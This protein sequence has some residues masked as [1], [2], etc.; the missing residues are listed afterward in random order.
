MVEEGPQKDCAAREVPVEAALCHVERLTKTIDA[1]SLN[2]L[3]DKD[4]LRSCKPVLRRQ[5]ALSLDG[6]GRVFWA[7]K[8]IRHAAMLAQPAPQKNQ[9][10]CLLAAEEIQLIARNSAF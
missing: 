5:R 7:G 3:S 6:L 1:N 9:I 10:S 8:G 2:P 4:V